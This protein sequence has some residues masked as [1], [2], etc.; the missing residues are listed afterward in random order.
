MFYIGARTRQAAFFNHY[1]G[2]HEWKGRVDRRGPKQYRDLSNEERG[3]EKKKKN[4]NR[5]KD[6]KSKNYHLW[7]KKMKM[8]SEEQK[9]TRTF[10]SNVTSLVLA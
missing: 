7:R 9:K 3:E 5:K 4:E 10:S 8:E 1:G 6:R 2:F